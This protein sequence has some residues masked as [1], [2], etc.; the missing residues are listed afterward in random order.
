MEAS[1]RSALGFGIVLILV[2]LAFLSGQ[3]FPQLWAWV[4]PM[5]WP[6]IVIGV[7]VALLVIG[8][9]TRQPDMAVPACIVG[10]IGGLLLWQNT[11]GN[12]G[13]WAYAWALIP[14]FAG[15][16]TMLA[17]LLKGKTRELR[18]GAISVLVSLVL[19][20]I[21]ASFLGGPAFLGRYWPILLIILGLIGIAQYFFHGKQ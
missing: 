16:G 18:D 12:W 1:R 5:S 7:G 15:V 10:G 13:S 17:G 6:F 8:L 11:T 4:G 14:G 2:G 21:F 19:F 9:M 3:I 20:A